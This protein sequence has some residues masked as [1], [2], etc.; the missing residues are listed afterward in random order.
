MKVEF[1]G[2]GALGTPANVRAVPTESKPFAETRA[3]ANRGP[4]IP[5]DVLSAPVEATEMHVIQGFRRWKSRR[6]DSNRGPLHYE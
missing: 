3:N 1:G 4:F 5:S 2:T 6:A